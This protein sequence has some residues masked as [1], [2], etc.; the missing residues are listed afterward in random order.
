MLTDSFRLLAGHWKL[1]DLAGEIADGMSPHCLA[2]QDLYDDVGV[3]EFVAGN[4]WREGRK[5]DPAG[6][7]AAVLKTLDA[8]IACERYRWMPQW[9]DKLRRIREDYFA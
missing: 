8:V 3:L 2:A 1:A 5:Y 7:S 4:P 6:S 9:T